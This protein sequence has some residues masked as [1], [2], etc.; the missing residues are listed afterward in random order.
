MN[1]AGA[2][3]VQPAVELDTVDA[4]KLFEVNFWGSVYCTKA[5]ARHMIPARSGKILQISSIAGEV[6]GPFASIYNASKFALRAYSDA[7]RLELRPF[8]VD[9]GIVNPG[10]VKSRIGV[11]NKESL[12]H[13]DSSNSNYKDFA[14]L[15]GS[16]MDRNGCPASHFQVLLR[17]KVA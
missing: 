14:V 6:S 7:A 9:V 12:A 2:V 3:Y 13:W 4:K 5:A 15:V 17:S 16:G 1:N 11:N 8:N 10:V